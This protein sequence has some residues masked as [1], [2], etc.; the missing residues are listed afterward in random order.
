MDDKEFV[1]DMRTYRLDH[2][3]DGYPCVQTQQIDR[4]IEIID[5]QAARIKHME[6]RLSI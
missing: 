2:L 6:M 4:L 1:D 5:R 3:P